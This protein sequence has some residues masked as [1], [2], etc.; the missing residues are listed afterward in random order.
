MTSGSVQWSPQ[1]QHPRIKLY[2]ANGFS[3]FTAAVDQAIAD[4]VDMILYSQVWEFGGNFDGG[5][6]INSA[7]NKATDAGILWINAAGNYAASSWQDDI[8]YNA[9]GVVELPFKQQYVRLVVNDADTNVKITL[10]WNDF[11]DTKDWRTPR[12]L[13]L[14]LLDSSEREIAASRLI[15]DGRDHGNDKLYSSHAR[16]SIST[17]LQPGIYVLK[18][19]AQSR[20]FDAQSRFRLAANGA[21]IAFIDQA[22][23][24]S[25]MIPADNPSVLTVG[26]SDDD[27]SSA[28][29]TQGGLHK[30]ELVAPSLIEVEGGLTFQGSSTAAAVTAA[31]LAVYQ[32]ACGFRM[33]RDSLSAKIL[34]G[35]ISQASTKGRG[36]WLHHDE[37]A[38]GCN[39]P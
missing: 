29:P 10:A 19:V 36:L 7:V 14:L 30:P 23:E 33:N 3:N 28:G 8:R 31:A 34:T 17:Q 12:D 1:S 35:V 21:N 37:W 32:D 38:R 9:N 2:N 25:V 11:A 39:A 26:S 24:A 27:N 6:F 13:D 20:N 5:G 4:R 18:V 15:Q 16:E 22:P